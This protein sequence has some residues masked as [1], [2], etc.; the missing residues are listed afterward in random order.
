MLCCGNRRLKK[1]T[2]QACTSTNTEYLGTDDA[3][4]HKDLKKKTQKRVDNKTFIKKLSIWNQIYTASWYSLNCSEPGIIKRYKITTPEKRRL[5]IEDFSECDEISLF[6]IKE[7][8]WHNS[9]LERTL[10]PY[11][12]QAC[13]KRTPHPL[14]MVDRIYYHN[15]DDI[16][17]LYKKLEMPNCFVKDH[18]QSTDGSNSLASLYFLFPKPHLI[19]CSQNYFLTPENIYQIS[20]LHENLR[21][22]K[23]NEQINYNSSKW[24]QVMLW[25]MSTNRKLQTSFD[26][27]YRDLKNA[28]NTSSN[29]VILKMAQSAEN[30]E[31]LLIRLGLNRGSAQ[32]LALEQ[33]IQPS[34]SQLFR[35]SWNLNQRNDLLT[36]QTCFDYNVS[37]D[38]I[39]IAFLTGSSYYCLHLVFTT[40]ELFLS[41]IRETDVFDN[42]DLILKSCIDE[43][44]YDVIRSLQNKASYRDCVPILV[45]K[46]RE[47][48]KPFL[49]KMQYIRLNEQAVTD[50]SLAFALVTEMLHKV[51]KIIIK[52][53]EAYISFNASNDAYSV[54]LTSTITFDI[55]KN[56]ILLVYKSFEKDFVT[57]NLLLSITKEKTRFSVTN[58]FL[59][60][61]AQ[62]ACSII[63]AYK[64]MHEEKGVPK[65]FIYLPEDY[66]KQDF[67]MLINELREESGHMI[68]ETVISQE[69]ASRLRV[70]QGTLLKELEK[71]LEDVNLLTDDS[72]ELLSKARQQRY[73]FYN[74]RFC[75]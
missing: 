7:S 21:F 1:E 64:I 41:K 39:W 57:E 62:M 25:W 26:E 17:Q 70:F 29:E 50:V 67:L 31:K 15:L 59:I 23:T 37:Q 20:S 47:K 38:S 19:S 65:S 11:F 3:L 72:N 60:N 12:S 16:M 27:L 63:S 52:N 69:S 68:L 58:L 54:D 8:K 18:D 6:D 48:L 28:Q 32:L 36:Y 30:L 33:Y 40:M 66:L 49:T 46:T 42:I 55:I 35:C 75:F 10:S 56:G 2:K 73:Y 44:Y 5:L 61:C 4:N 13:F 45:Q 71:T 53:H 51:I 24:L 22:C 43:F 34:R 14:S 9:V 74:K